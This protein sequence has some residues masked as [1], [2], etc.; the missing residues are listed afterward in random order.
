MEILRQIISKDAE[1]IISNLKKKYPKNRC[2]IPSFTLRIFI[3][4]SVSNILKTYCLIIKILF[5][6]IDVILV[7][8]NCCFFLKKRELIMKRG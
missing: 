8:L 4:V 6:C 3:A 1:K 5:F 2:T 7:F